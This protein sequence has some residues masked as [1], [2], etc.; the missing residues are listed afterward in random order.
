METT[1]AACVCPASIKRVHARHLC[2]ECLV[3][4]GD[5]RAGAVIIANGAV[6]GVHTETVNQARERLQRSGSISDRL[7]DVDRSVD[8]IG[9]F[10]Y[11]YK[12][13]T[14]KQ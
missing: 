11:L 10:L 12:I 4:F 8:S 14:V 6:I 3:Y 1:H 5:S 9:P 2:Y 7:D 13:I